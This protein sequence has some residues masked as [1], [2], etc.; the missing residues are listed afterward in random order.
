MTDENMGP[1]IGIDEITGLLEG[2]VRP[3]VEIGLLKM[4]MG[5]GEEKQY[6]IRAKA[7]HSH[8]TADSIATGW[9]EYLSM[10]LEKK[11]EITLNDSLLPQNTTLVDSESREAFD[12]TIDQLIIRKED[13]P[14]IMGLLRQILFESRN[15]V[16]LLLG[17]YIEKQSEGYIARQSQQ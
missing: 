3:Y 2:Y 16:N 9:V 15:R 8:E 6:E 10:A 11:S 14:P 17:I 4:G 7:Y 12:E 1:V 5:F 13:V